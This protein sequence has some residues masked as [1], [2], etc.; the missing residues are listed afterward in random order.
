MKTKKYHSVG[1][2]PKYNRKIVYRD[3]IDIPNTQIHD[4]SPSWFGTGPNTQIHDQSPSWFGTG[5]NTQ[6]HDQSPSWFG[7]GRNTQIHDQSP[8]KVEG[9]KETKLKERKKTICLKYSYCCIS[10]VLQ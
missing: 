5:R 3:K 9:L 6:I 8:S 10:Y 2:V 7:T 4:Q 1:T